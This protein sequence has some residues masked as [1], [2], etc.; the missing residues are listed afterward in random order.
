MIY[1]IKIESEKMKIARKIRLFIFYMTWNFLN[2]IA[3]KFCKNKSIYSMIL[4]L[5]SLV[6]NHDNLMLKLHPK[7]RY[8]DEG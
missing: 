8:L 3:L 7:N 5:L 2:M 6:F 1:F 4:T